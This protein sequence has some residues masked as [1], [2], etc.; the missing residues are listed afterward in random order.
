MKH[1]QVSRSKPLNPLN[2][3]LR[4]SAIRGCPRDSRDDTLHLEEERG[5]DLLSHSQVVSKQATTPQKSSNLLPSELPH[6]AFCSLFWTVS[7]SFV[8]ATG[9]ATRQCLVQASCTWMPGCQAALIALS[10]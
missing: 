2:R 8:F 3:R 5:G 7:E 10:G 1:N 4:C 9:L 6:S